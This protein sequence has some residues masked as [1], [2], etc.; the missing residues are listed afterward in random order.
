[1]KFQYS[2]PFIIAC[3][4]LSSLFYLGTSNRKILLND[5]RQELLGD[6]PLNQKDRM[7]WEF[8]RLRNPKTGKIPNNIRKYSLDYAMTLPGSIKY[9]NFKNNRVQ[10]NDWILRGPVNVGG[11]T[12]A[13]AID[14]LDENIIIAG[15]VSGGMWRSDDGGS[16]WIKTTSPLQLQSTSCIAQDIR[17]GKENIW[18][19]GTGEYFNI[20]GGLRGDGIYKSTDNG[21]SWFLLKST[22]SNSPQSWDNGFDYV[23]NIITDHKNP[24]ED[25]VYAAT[26]VGAINRSTDGGETW[27]RVLGGFGNAYS[28]FTDIAITPSGVLYATFSQKTFAE[29]D[30]SAVKGI[31]RSLD[32]INWT[33]ITPPFIPEKYRRIVIG[34]SA[35]DEDQVYFLAET[36]MSGQMTI[37][38]RGDSLWHSIWNYTYVSGD[39]TG[40]GGIWENRSEYIPAPKRIRSQFNSQGSY[41]LVIKVK[42]D[43]PNVVF[44]GGTNLYRSTDGFT[45]IK[46]TSHIGGYC[47]NDTAC[48]E[49]YTYTN[50]HA[51]EHAIIFL[52]SNPNVMFTGSDG[53]IAKTLDNTAEHVDWQSLN[54]GYFTTQFYT[55]RID[56][57]T[58]S[59]EIIGGLQDN[60]TL[61]TN[62][63]DIN[64]PWTSP[65]GA[66]GFCC[67]ISD[68]G[69]SYYTS[70]NS[71]YQPYIKIYKVLLDDNG[72]RI[73]RRRIDPIGGKDFIWNTPFILDPNNTNIMYLAGGRMIWRNND[74]G[75]IEVDGGKDS[76][77]TQ[78]DSLSYTKLDS[79][80]PSA[81]RGERITAISSSKNPSDILYYGTSYGRVFRID[82][83]NQGNPKPKDITDNKFPD[84]ANV[85]CV[86]IN[87]DDA[88]KIFVVFTNFSVQSIFYSKNGGNSWENVSGNLEQF[89]TG[90][91]SGPACYWLEVLPVKGKYLYLV[92]TSTG[93]YSTSLLDSNYTVWQQEGANTL[94]NDMVYMLDSRASDG[95]VTA[96]SFGVGMFSSNINTLA[97]APDNPTLLAPNNGSKGILKSTILKWQLVS[98]A[99]FYKLIVA[100]DSEFSNIIFEEDGLKNDSLEVYN[101]Q[102]GLKN[103]YWE[104]I[105]R[106]SGG[107][108]KPS[109]IWSF[110]TAASPPE[111]V[112]PL[113]NSDSV[114]LPIKLEWKQSD[115]AEQYHLQISQNLI[116]SKINVDTI[117]VDNQYES[118]NFLDNQ[119]YYWHVSAINSGNE[120]IFSDKFRFKT[121]QIVNVNEQSDKKLS[122]KV[123]PNPSSNITHLKFWANKDEKVIIL[124][125]NSEGKAIRTI[126]NAFFGR[127]NH[128]LIVKTS[129]LAQGL[130]YVKIK[131]GEANNIKILNIIR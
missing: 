61:Y 35:S 48:A 64:S 114:E 120:G 101:L 1:M 60:G 109:T 126:V 62:S 93:I 5:N 66:D 87:P 47:W 2:L 83:A 4:F 45:S 69:K 98:N 103:Y 63:T 57:A 112:S 117:L 17:K 23:W 71:S 38:S 105:A 29:N 59:N 14:V 6:A 65:A 102:Q 111:L 39:G 27:K 40:D 10:S 25:V 13:L 88:N 33:D 72:E 85:G 43:N 52:P 107:I 115:G 118:S 58:N 76:I 110:T 49:I 130:Y 50:H 7:L 104:V 81:Y 12:R 119:R 106:G 24:D 79:I 128:S 90:A 15:G 26:A 21:H 95:F 53:G 94:G 9:F 84:L 122:F 18:Y 55:C 78:W 16:N 127:G 73:K 34:I 30:D 86:A 91:G 116:F 41:D 124:L 19:V 123:Y 3:L 108:S 131:V 70:Q 46:N 80:N 68:S 99:Y 11:R 92:G 113:N 36:P 82:A 22:V 129:N 20:Y 97:N 75:A 54:N 32:G 44:I 51:D 56:H 67:A 37:N 8:L 31:F 89:L 77:E 42:P 125:Y 28:W 96:A 121:K 100:E 74:L